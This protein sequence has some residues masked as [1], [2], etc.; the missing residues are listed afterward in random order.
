MEDHGERALLLSR[1][2]ERDARNEFPL[3]LPNELEQDEEQKAAEMTIGDRA[4][5]KH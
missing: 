4:N 1:I 3:V 5:G 2:A